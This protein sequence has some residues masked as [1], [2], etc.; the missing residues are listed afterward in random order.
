MEKIVFQSMPI[1]FTLENGLIFKVSIVRQKYFLVNCN[2]SK[3]KK[4]HFK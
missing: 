3:R 2:P 4:K 1:E